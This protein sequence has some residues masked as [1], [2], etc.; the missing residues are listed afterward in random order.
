[1]L[2]ILLSPDLTLSLEQEAI[3][4]DKSVNDIINDA[5]EN[6]LHARQQAKIDQ[7]IVAYQ[8]MHTQLKR[9]LLG[10]WVAIHNQKLIDH[11][12]DR[13]A[14]YRRIRARYGRNPILIRQVREQPI[15]E[16]FARTPNTGRVVP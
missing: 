7:E 10:E 15:E 11:D 1:M 3:E 8:T 13:V 9:D 16:L 5:V 2:S 12:R 4:E 6:Y 14:L